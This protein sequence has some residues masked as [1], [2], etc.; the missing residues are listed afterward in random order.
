MS[1]EVLKFQQHEHVAVL[2]INRPEA[3]NALNPE[4]LVRL[5]RAWQRVREDDSIRA[6]VISGT[7]PAFSAG[8][9]LG[10]M[11]PLIT[12]ARPAED[13]WDEALLAD[14]DLTHRATLRN[15]DTTKPV[16]AAING[17][18]IAGGLE[19]VMGCDLRIAA[20]EARFGLQ[21]VKWGLF[22]GGGSTVRLPRQLP[23][24]R[25]MEMLLTGKLYDAAS[26]NDWG[27]LNDVVAVDQVLDSAM[28]LASEIAQNG[29]VAVR[30]VRR[31]AR[32]SSGV[33]E[34]DALRRESELSAPVYAT[35]DAKEGPRA[36]MEKR[37]PV[38]IGR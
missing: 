15:F 35:E 33:P 25:A 2:I 23:Y 38:F 34:R 27:F 6:A 36:F 10:R 24:C 29:P 12:G 17:F 13:E 1:Y 32:E 18:A 30:A 31:S 7:G 16:I 19:L 14:Q 5:E 9:D 20:A 21:E 4:I 22:P 28:K 3:R 37:R 26:M 8:M 11:I